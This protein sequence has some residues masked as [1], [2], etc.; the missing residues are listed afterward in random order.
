VISGNAGDGVVISADN[1]TNAV[2]GHVVQGNFIGTDVSGAV[3]LGNTGNGVLIKQKASGN[4][5]GGPAGTANTI[6]FNGLAGVRVDS[7]NR[8]RISRNSIF[9]NAGLGIA[10][11]GA[12]NANNRQ[13]APQL[14]SA[15]L[16]PAGTV[17]TIQGRLTGKPST[18]FTLEFFANSAGDPEGKKFLGAKTVTTNPRGIVNFSFKFTVP[19]GI[20][21]IVATATDPDGNTSQFFG[22]AVS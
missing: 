16:N 18:T 13:K 7:G 9:S 2:L 6:A 14:T 1:A 22:R 3:A 17:V 19:S 4:I 11:I 21:L 5:I 15:V 8:N 12:N 20:D 10:L